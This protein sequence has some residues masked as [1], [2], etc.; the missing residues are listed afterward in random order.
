MEWLR[1]EGTLKIPSS[2]SIFAFGYVM[3]TWDVFFCVTAVAAPSWPGCQV[4]TFR[5]SH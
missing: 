2:S 3:Q 1:L 5:V 4:L